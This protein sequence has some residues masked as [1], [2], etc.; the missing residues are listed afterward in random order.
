MKQNPDNIA[1]SIEDP[2]D[3]QHNPGKSMTINSVQYNKFI[4]SMKKEINFILNGEYVKR[5]DKIISGGNSNNTNTGINEKT[6]N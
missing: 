4:T 2:F 5:L 3:V 6:N 1:F